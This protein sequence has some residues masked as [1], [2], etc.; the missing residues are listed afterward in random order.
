VIARISIPRESVDRG[1]TLYR[2]ALSGGRPSFY[3]LSGSSG[4]SVFDQ[5]QPNQ[6]MKLSWC[7]GPSKGNRPVLMAAATPRSLWAIR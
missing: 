3:S 7:G 1:A 4:D 5:R 2:N 6:P